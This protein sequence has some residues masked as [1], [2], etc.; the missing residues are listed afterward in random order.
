MKSIV[1]KNK[2]KCSAWYIK[3]NK[4]NKRSIKHGDPFLYR[5]MKRN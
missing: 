4:R 3:K 5:A 1:K 2:I